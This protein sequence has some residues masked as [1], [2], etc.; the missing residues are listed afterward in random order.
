MTDA[1]KIFI[2]WGYSDVGGHDAA[3]KAK[4]LAHGEDVFYFNQGQFEQNPQEP[5]FGHKSG[6]GSSTPMR[7]FATG[8]G[9]ADTMNEVRTYE[10]RFKA[11]VHRL[12]DVF[13][14]DSL[15]IFNMQTDR[16]ANGR[17]PHDVQVRVEALRHEMVDVTHH[18]PNC[19]AVRSHSNW[20]P[21]HRGEPSHLAVSGQVL[22]GHALAD[23]VFDFWV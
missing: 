15:P 12:R 10:H 16:I 6:A 17:W 1:K 13:D 22:F 8:P 21:V 3:R 19:V 2:V 18:V 9:D 23:A 20:Q 14:D 4:P 7:Y 11:L 5:V